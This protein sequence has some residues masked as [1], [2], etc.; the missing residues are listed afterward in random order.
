MAFD[1][2]KAV[3]CTFSSSLLPRKTILLACFGFILSFFCENIWLIT[4]KQLYLHQQK[5]TGLQNTASDC[6]SGGKGSEVL[7]FLTA[8]FQNTASD[9]RSEG[10]GSETLFLVSIGN[11]VRNAM[12]KEL[13]PDGFVYNNPTVSLCYFGPEKMTG[14]DIISPFWV[15]DRIKVFRLLHQLWQIKQRLVLFG[16]MAMR[17]V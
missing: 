6:S 10:K 7:I 1:A 14:N 5:T 4:N 12:Y 17:L 9:C 2:K 3:F 13:T 15:S 11:I 16:I 8:E